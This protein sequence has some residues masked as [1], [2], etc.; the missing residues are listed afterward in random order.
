[1]RYLVRVGWV[2]TFHLFLKIDFIEKD[3]LRR[4]EAKTQKKWQIVMVLFMVR[5][6]KE[7]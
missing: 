5:K 6:F 1:M 2:V 4:R 7:S 3:T